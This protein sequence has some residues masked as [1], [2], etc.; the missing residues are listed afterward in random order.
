[1]MQYKLTKKRLEIIRYLNFIVLGQPI[2]AGAGSNESSAPV[3]LNYR[4]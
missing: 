2:G 1:M 4:R 3:K